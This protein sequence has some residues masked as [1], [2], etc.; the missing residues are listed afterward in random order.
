MIT[1]GVRELKNKLSHYLRSVKQGRPVEITERGESIAMLVPPRQS[2]SA[3][4]AEA[5]IRKGIGSWKGGKPK[6]A[7]RRVTV[8]G[9]PVSQIVIEERR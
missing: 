6:G 3:Q 8:K 1:V 4:I 2:S 7:S 5:L 9:K